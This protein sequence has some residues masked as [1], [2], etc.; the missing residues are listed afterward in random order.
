MK[1]VIIVFFSF[2]LMGQTKQVLTNPMFGNVLSNSMTNPA[3][4]KDEIIDLL[5]LKIISESFNKSTL[6]N[7]KYEHK[8]YLTET[9]DTD[10]NSFNIKWIEIVDGINYDN[11][12]GW[13]KEFHTQILYL[14][15]DEWVIQSIINHKEKNDKNQ[16]IY[17]FKKIIIK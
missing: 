15:D 9:N 5:Y 11:S 4:S 2:I 12:I 3:I 13:K 10:M 6:P 14:L 8:L 17:V 16:N 1:I 7:Y